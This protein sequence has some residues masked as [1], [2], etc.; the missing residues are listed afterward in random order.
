MRYNLL[1]LLSL[2]R[3]DDD[4]VALADAPVVAPVHFLAQHLDAPGQLEVVEEVLVQLA[5][6]GRLVGCAR[7]RGADVT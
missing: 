5:E 1:A 2:E 7:K 6:G 4:S 3:E